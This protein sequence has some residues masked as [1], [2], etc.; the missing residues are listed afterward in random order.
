[1]AKIKF[2]GIRRDCDVA[3]ANRLGV[4]YI[5][6]VFAPRSKRCVTVEKAKELRK[7]L[8]PDIKAVGVFV[9]APLHEIRSLY[10][11]GVIQIAQIHGTE[12]ES[13]INELKKMEGL[14]VIDAISIKSEKDVAKANASKADFVMVDSVKAGSGKTFDWELLEGMSREYFL[15]GGLTI[16]NVGEAVEKLNPFAVDVSTGI[17]EAP[18]VKNKDKMEAFVKNVKLVTA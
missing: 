7:Q 15:A 10:E 4:D 14:T 13:Y 6:F 1:M 8:N 11:D 5:G 9:N 3:E 16:D 18:G 12:P 17:E 2:C